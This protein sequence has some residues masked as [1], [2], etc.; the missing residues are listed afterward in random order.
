METKTETEK[1]DEYLAEDEPLPG[2]VMLRRPL[3]RTE[4][5]TEL[6]DWLWDTGHRVEGF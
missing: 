2:T 3:Y 6:V 4:S 5:H 1:D